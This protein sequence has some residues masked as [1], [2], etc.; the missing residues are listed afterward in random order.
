M[1]D[2]PAPNPARDRVV[3]GVAYAEKRVA[4][5]AVKRRA[6]DR[7][8]EDALDALE[9]ASRR[10]AAWDEANPEPQGCLRLVAA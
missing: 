10:L 7:E 4:R 6:A 1:I 2:D 3:A 8:M 5:A 9:G